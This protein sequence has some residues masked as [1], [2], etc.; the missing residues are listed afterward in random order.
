MQSK[1]SAKFPSGWGH[2]NGPGAAV[3]VV[4]GSLGSLV[5]VGPVYTVVGSGAAVE[6]VEIGG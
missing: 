1:G 6:V 4:L 5:V 2:W 3:V